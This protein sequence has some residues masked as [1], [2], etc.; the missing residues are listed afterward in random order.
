MF[1]NY[2]KIAWRILGRHKFFSGIS[3]FGIS[4]TLGIL[5]V[6]IS[7]LQSELGT[8]APLSNKDNL[9]YLDLLKLETIMY[10]TITTIDTTVF[11]GE[12]V[13]D[14]TFQT[15]ESGSMQWNSEM[16]N[17]IA[18]KYLSN[19]PSVREHTVFSAG[20]S[21]DFYVNN[22]KIQYDALYGDPSY[23]S[24]FNH[25]ILEG[26]VIDQ[27]DMD[28]ASKVMLMSDEAA[29]EYFGSWKGVVGKEIEF[30]GYNYS[31]IGIYRHAGKF[32]PFVSPDIVLPY[33][34][35]NPDDQ[36]SFYHGFYSVM[37]VKKSSLDAQK[38]KQEIIDA[39]TTV[40]LDH[41]TKPDGFETVVFE[42][43][44]Y[45]EMFAL[46]LY[47]DEDETKSLRIMK[48]IVLSLLVFFIILPTL[49][50]VN[51]NVSRILDRSSEI[52]VR[53]AFGAHQGNIMLQ[54]VIENVV[55]TMIGGIIGLG[56][57]MLFISFINSGGHLG[58]AELSLSPKFFLLCFVTT[59][60]FGVIS[61]LVPAFRI[62]R[63][64]IVNALNQ[65]KL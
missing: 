43:T 46:E 10:D 39:A 31:I 62:S 27:N 32:V 38:V 23:W 58:S 11:N 35:L 42:P 2:L 16:N 64:N 12:T 61:G 7:F 50:L 48:W 21:V 45:E 52:G 54:F 47:Y 57:A 65:K 56:I 5:M 29:I 49:N 44:T 34:V 63:L 13:F 19:L 26:R 33:S 3:L 36:D 30:D 22:V 24:V 15:E 55:L 9:I 28:R 14:T 20:N 37:F 40:P 25:T 51:L 60:V 4:F 53:K 59:I 41:P 1:I 17:Q 6:F 8:D 18:E